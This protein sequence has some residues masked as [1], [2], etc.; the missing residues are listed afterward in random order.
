MTNS[1]IEF[2][3][4]TPHSSNRQ[5]APRPPRVAVRGLFNLWVYEQ[6]RPERD[7]MPRLRTSLKLRH[8]LLAEP[9]GGM[10]RA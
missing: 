1:L 6:H 9:A 2:G 10:T 3:A 4:G 7:S 5:L 8:G